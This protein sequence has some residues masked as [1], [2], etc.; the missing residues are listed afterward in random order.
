MGL[1]RPVAGQLLCDQ[2]SKNPTQQ[3]K[4]K[5]TQLNVKFKLTRQ[6]RSIP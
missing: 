1:C 3:E 4:K 5:A 2:P 6:R